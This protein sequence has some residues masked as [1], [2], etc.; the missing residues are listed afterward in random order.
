MDS[1]VYC[2]I[3]QQTWVCVHSDQSSQ[4]VLQAASP[5]ALGQM[6]FLKSPKMW[7]PV[8]QSFNFEDVFLFLFE[9][10]INK[11]QA[12]FMDRYPQSDVLVSE[13]K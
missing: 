4:A 2:F 9:R 7:F 6:A 1:A 13:G 12:L 5:P 8:P 10:K 3:P 11:G